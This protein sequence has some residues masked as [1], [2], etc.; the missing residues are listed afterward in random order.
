MIRPLQAFT[1]HN[2]ITGKTVAKATQQASREILPEVNSNDI[3][4]DLFINVLGFKPYRKQVLAIAENGSK[5]SVCSLSLQAVEGPS[6][7]INLKQHPP[8]EKAAN[9]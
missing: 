4:G 6:F 8:L 5:E 7:K 3:P 9:L 1:T 2:K